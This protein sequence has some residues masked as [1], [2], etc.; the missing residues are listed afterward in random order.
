M[1]LELKGKKKAVL[2]A[3]VDIKRSVFC[4]NRGSFSHYP[5]GRVELSFFFF[6]LLLCVKQKWTT[7][8]RHISSRT[9]KQNDNNDKKRAWGKVE[10]NRDYRMR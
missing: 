6:V 4:V 3:S 5:H 2:D 9:E 8:Q 7:E 10:I 1:L